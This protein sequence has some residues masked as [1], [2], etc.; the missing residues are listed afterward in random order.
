MLKSSVKKF[1]VQYFDQYQYLFKQKQNV[2]SFP[3]TGLNLADVCR[4][5]YPKA[6]R[7]ALW[8]MMEIAIIGSDIQEVIGSAIAL[9]LLSNHK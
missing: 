7:L 3:S 4:L 9:N 6:P 8:I 5:E 1:T 2:C